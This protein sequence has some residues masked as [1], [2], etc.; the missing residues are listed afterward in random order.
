MAG[1]V[2]SSVM[3]MSTSLKCPMRTGAV[4]A[5]FNAFTPGYRGGLFVGV[6]PALSGGR[7][8]VVVS[9]DSV[10]D[11]DGSVFSNLF[12]GLTLLVCAVV[13]LGSAPRRYQAVAVMAI[14]DQLCH[15]RRN[16]SH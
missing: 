16:R 6:V 9:K 8:S 7:G 1:E 5:D 4:R 12:P 14:G 10:T 13:G 3:K 2:I 11:Y 15:V